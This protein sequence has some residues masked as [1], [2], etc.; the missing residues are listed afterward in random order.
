M[1]I[2]LHSHN[3]TTL[4][5]WNLYIQMCFQL[6]RIV[7]PMGISQSNVISLGLVTQRKFE[8]VTKYSIYFPWATS[9][10]MFLWVNAAYFFLAHVNICLFEKSPLEDNNM[11]AML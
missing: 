1:K 7:K 4:R 8:C 10:K 5:Y 2:Q 11:N 3:E 6:L 9:F